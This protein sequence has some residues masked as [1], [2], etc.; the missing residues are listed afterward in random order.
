ME[1]GNIRR[2][3]KILI[4]EVYIFVSLL[5]ERVILF[6][7]FFFFFS[8]FK[9]RASISSSIPLTNAISSVII[10]LKLKLLEYLNHGFTKPR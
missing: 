3:C 10:Y 2:K 7:I 1:G 6:Q 5:I 9:K 4:N 8:I